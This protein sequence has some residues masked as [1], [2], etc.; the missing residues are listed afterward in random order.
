MAGALAVA[1]LA[2]AVGW[3]LALSGRSSRGAERASA[4]KKVI[5]WSLDLRGD[6]RILT[7]MD[8]QGFALSPDGR[9]L[10]W[11]GPREPERRIFLQ[12]GGAFVPLDATYPAERLAFMLKDSAAPVML[13]QKSLAE[14]LPAGRTQVVCLDTEWELISR[15]S[16]EDPAAAVSNRNLAYLI[17]TSGSTGKPKGTAIQHEGVINL[18]VDIE[19]RMPLAES[20]AY[21][22]WG[23]LSFDVSVYE[24]FSSLVA[25]GTLHIVPEELRIDSFS[26]F[27]WL[28]SRKIESAYITPSMLRDVADWLDQDANTLS[29]RRL[30][31]GVEPIQQ[32]LLET[33]RARVPGLH[34]INGYGPTEATICTTLYSL[35][36][37]IYGDRRTPIGQP[38]QNYDVYILDRNLQAV[39]VGVP[40]ELHVGGLGL[41]RGYGSDSGMTA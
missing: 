15:H 31:V 40:G 12:A 10:A 29:L 11:I 2:A 3:G 34:I 8:N 16:D 4:A 18:L 21:C 24:I 1:T 14:Q 26:F 13:T 36:A 9:Q 37:Q 33:I 38:V 25:G 6:Q 32:S 5:R 28:S 17:Y 35:P 39:P 22:F 19:D 41:S 23:S 20:A 30:L 7:D 27:E